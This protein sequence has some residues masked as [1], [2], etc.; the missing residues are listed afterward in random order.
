[1]P[2]EP[3]TVRNM[4]EPPLK[5]GDELVT[6]SGH[7]KLYVEGQ[8]AYFQ[9]ENRRYLCHVVSS[10]NERYITGSGRRE[11]RCRIVA[12]VVGY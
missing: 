10:T 1:M 9:F 2:R 7:R 4:G 12:V 8:R 5:P 11:T 3:F 6:K